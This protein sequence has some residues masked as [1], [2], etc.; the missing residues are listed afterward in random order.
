MELVGD[1]RGLETGSPVTG[2]ERKKA[3]VTCCFQ[4]ASVVRGR[5]PS[6]TQRTPHDLHKMLPACAQGPCHPTGREIVEQSD[7][8]DRGPASQI[9]L[10]PTSWH[11]LNSAGPSAEHSPVPWPAASPQRQPVWP[12]LQLAPVRPLPT[13]QTATPWMLPRAAWHLPSHPSA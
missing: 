4:Y 2:V 1:V 6:P 9:C 3:E 8:P 12:C 11:R 10:S 13:S 5:S 7:S